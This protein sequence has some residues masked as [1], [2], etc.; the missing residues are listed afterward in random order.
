MLSGAQRL[1]VR[2]GQRSFPVP[3]FPAIPVNPNMSSIGVTQIC[4]V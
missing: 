2:H 1:Q 4:G 3:K